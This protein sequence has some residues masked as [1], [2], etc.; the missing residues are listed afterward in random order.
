MVTVNDRNVHVRLKPSE[1]R[2]YL[3]M[4]KNLSEKLKLQRST[5]IFKHISVLSV[6]GMK[7]DTIKTTNLY[8]LIRTHATGVR[9]SSYQFVVNA[10]FVVLFHVHL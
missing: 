3:K 4:L 7:I 6:P 1:N 5:D 8:E 9:T 2:N 10:Y